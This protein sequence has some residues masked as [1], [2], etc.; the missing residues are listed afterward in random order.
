MKKVIPTGKDV[1][2]GVNTSME[3]VIPTGEYVEKGGKCKSGE[4]NNC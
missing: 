3:K 2:K 4:C 1:E